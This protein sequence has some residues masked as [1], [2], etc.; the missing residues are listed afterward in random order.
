MTAKYLSKEQAFDAGQKAIQQIRFTENLERQP[1]IQSFL[2]L[3]KKKNPFWSFRKGP[4]EY[5]D[6]LCSDI[7]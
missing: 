5:Y 3:N 6:L 1:E 2:F 4:W 7:I